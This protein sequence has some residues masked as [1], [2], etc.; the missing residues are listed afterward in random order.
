VF[1]YLPVNV[2][3]NLNKIAVAEY[4]HDFIYGEDLEIDRKYQIINIML[5]STKFGPAPMVY[6]DGAGENVSTEKIPRNHE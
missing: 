2:F 4:S 6:L 3:E 5:V 1:L